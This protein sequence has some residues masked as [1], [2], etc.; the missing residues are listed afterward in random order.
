MS[1]F[2]EEATCRAEVQS[3]PAGRGWTGRSR[4]WGCSRLVQSLRAVTRWGPSE[5]A[6]GLSLGVEKR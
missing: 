4:V 2:L 5:I 1:G 3:Y 6:E